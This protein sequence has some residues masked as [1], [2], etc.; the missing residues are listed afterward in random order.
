MY[1][2]Q[3]FDILPEK[4]DISNNS[5]IA[6]LRKISLAYLAKN[7][8]LLQKT[9]HSPHNKIKNF[10]ITEKKNFVVVYVCLEHYRLI[11]KI[12]VTILTK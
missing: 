12:F 5:F 8:N 7:L 11:K 4:K 10:N 9:F 6:V 3:E 1:K 2:R